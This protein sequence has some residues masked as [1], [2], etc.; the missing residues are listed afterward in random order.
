VPAGAVETIGAPD[1]PVIDLAG[2]DGDRRR[3][4]PVG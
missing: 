3:P 4:T 2:E 1:G